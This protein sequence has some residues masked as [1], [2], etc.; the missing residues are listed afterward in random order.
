MVNYWAGD[1]L[2]ARAI[3]P[4]RA[5]SSTP[6]VVI[7]ARNFSTLLSVAGD[8]DGEAAGLDVHDLGPENI[9]HL[10]DLGAGL[11]VDRDAHQNQ[12]AINEI[13]LPEIHHLQDVDQFVELFDD[14]IQGGV[15]A[16]GDDGH[17]R[18]GGLLGGGDVEGFDIVAAAAEKAGD[19]R[20]HAELVF[21]Q[22]GY[23]MTH[24]VARVLGS[25][26]GPKNPA[27]PRERRPAREPESLPRAASVNINCANRGRQTGPIFHRIAMAAAP[28]NPQIWEIRGRA[29]S[30]AGWAASP[31][32]KMRK[33]L[34]ERQIGMLCPSAAC[35]RPR[36]PAQGLGALRGKSTPSHQNP[37]LSLQKCEKVLLIECR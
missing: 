35:R 16:A 30:P 22:H 36:E 15:V 5:S 4:V 20:E 34:I 37:T 12:F 23:C 3:F 2:R 10:H 19:A 25:G 27:F 24:N 11:G 18:G 9:G 31:F 17:A 28:V 32:S 29:K 7:R 26:S 6:K 33:C 21:H 13:I 1:G 8:F 14:L